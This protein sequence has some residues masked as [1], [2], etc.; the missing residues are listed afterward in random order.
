MKC[1]AQKENIIVQKQ[2]TLLFYKLI[3]IGKP[4][5]IQSIV[6]YIYAF[7]DYRFVHYV[8]KLLINN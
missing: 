3:Q 4:T 7:T 1:I 8:L 5:E 6:I 2:K